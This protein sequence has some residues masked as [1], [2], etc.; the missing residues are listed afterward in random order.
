MRVAGF[1]A[2]KTETQL[3][4]SKLNRTI[5]SDGISIKATVHAVERMKERGIS[6]DSIVDA[7]TKPLSSGTIKAD[8][9]GNE[10]NSTLVRKQLP[11]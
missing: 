4:I 8:D 9:K 5:T 7:L 3:A 10:A 6:A 11:P 2:V 1:R